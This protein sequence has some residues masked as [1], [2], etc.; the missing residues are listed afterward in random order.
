MRFEENLWGLNFKPDKKIFSIAYRTSFVY[1]LN[2]YSLKIVL[3]IEYPKL[4]VKGTNSVEQG[5]IA[6]SCSTTEQNR[7]TDQTTPAIKIG[8]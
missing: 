5:K 4:N 2:Q 6:I 7:S 3:I 1:C 8:G